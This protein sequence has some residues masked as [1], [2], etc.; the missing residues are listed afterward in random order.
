[1]SVMYAFRV[2]TIRST[3]TVMHDTRRPIYRPMS[4]F[5]Y[6]LRYIVG[7]G[8]VVMAISTNTKA[9]IYRNLPLSS[10]VLCIYDRIDKRVCHA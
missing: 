1:M 4:V 7:F 6:N 3:I 2:V 9:T 10:L 8:L 5:S